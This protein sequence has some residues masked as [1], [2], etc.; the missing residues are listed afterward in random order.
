MLLEPLKALFVLDNYIIRYIVGVVGNPK[1]KSKAK[2]NL[3][4][5]L[6]AKS[7]ELT[8]EFKSFECLICF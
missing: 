2:S 5:K 6:K 7:E 3:S 1:S 4:P 8:V